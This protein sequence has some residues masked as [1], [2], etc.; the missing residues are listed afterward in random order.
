MAKL[1]YTVEHSIAQLSV[2]DLKILVANS[3]RSNVLMG[4]KVEQL[5]YMPYWMVKV[6]I[7]DL[8]KSSKLTELIQKFTD[9]PI[10]KI[11]RQKHSELFSFVMW[12]K[13]ELEA[14]YKLES[15]YLSTPPDND[16][17]NAGIRELDELGEFN[18]IDNLVKEWHGA[19]THEELKLK[20]YHFIFDKLRK[21][22]LEAKITKQHNKIQL[23]KQKRRK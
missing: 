13:D 9:Q 15:E 11:C 6:E 5:I 21:S 10:K 8:L 18:T 1:I 20:P 4:K 14:I 16:L 7:P 17:I 2:D 23:D 3:K 19:Y 12:V 22:T